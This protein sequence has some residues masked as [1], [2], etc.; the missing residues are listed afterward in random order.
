MSRAVRLQKASNRNTRTHWL[1]IGEMD[2]L[3]SYETPVA[4]RYGSKV[5]R[6]ENDWGPTTGRHF[7]EGGADGWPCVSGD[8]FE[9]VLEDTF[10]QSFID[11]ITAELRRVA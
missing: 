11:E 9:R 7:K 6:R 8:Q 10:R 3:F 2:V 4:F 1:C 5:L